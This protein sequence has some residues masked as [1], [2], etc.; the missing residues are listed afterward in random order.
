MVFGLKNIITGVTGVFVEPY[1]GAKQN[2]FSGGIRGVGKGLLGLVCKPVAGTLDLV[3]FLV[4]G[5]GNTPK[6]IYGKVVR[7]YRKRK[8]KKMLKDQQSNAEQYYSEQEQLEFSQE[9]DIYTEPHE[10]G[11]FID[12]QPETDAQLQL[13]HENWHEQLW[14]DPAEIV[15][16]VFEIDE[17]DFEFEE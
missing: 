5:V 13:I 11:V 8:A 6:T 3:T 15:Q 9:K 1:K 4:R 16:D 10:Q 14:I 7:T 2:G 12:G 17:E